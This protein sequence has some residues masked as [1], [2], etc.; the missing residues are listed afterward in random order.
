MQALRVGR[1]LRGDYIAATGLDD[2]I[3]ADVTVYSTDV[4]R[5]VDT[6]H[7]LLLGL[8]SDANATAAAEA[9]V[10]PGL[11][12]CRPNFGAR[13]PVPCIAS[14]LGL[15]TPAVGALPNV[16]VRDN[17][18]DLSMQQANLCEGWGDWLGRVERS[19]KWRDAPYE[20]LKDAA[21]AVGLVTG[22]ESLLQRRT[23]P[24]R[25]C[26]SCTNTT[27]VGFNKVGLLESVRRPRSPQVQ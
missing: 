3:A 15:P 18:A 11:C 25:A 8:F 10:R 5:T 19:A 27:A 17:N 21:A 22:D 20:R 6:A 14:C 13:S 24:G 7:A 1:R 12:A 23:W 4:D 26:S 16:T 9:A 2:V